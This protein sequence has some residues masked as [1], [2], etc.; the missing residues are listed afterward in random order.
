MVLPVFWALT[1][2]CNLLSDE[3]SLEDR[4]SI[5]VVAVSNA[6]QIRVIISQ[7]YFLL[8]ALP[9]VHLTG[10]DKIEWK[11]SDLHIHAH[12]IVISYLTR[13][14]WKSLKG[15][16]EEKG[17]GTVVAEFL[18]QSVI[19]C[20]QWNDCDTNVHR[21]ATVCPQLCATMW[22]Q[23]ARNCGT[24]YPQSIT[25]VDYSLLWNISTIRSIFHQDPQLIVSL[26][27]EELHLGGETPFQC[28]RRA[29]CCKLR[30]GRATGTGEKM[31]LQRWRGRRT[32][33]SLFSL[34]RCSDG[35][36]GTERGHRR[37]R[38][39]RREGHEPTPPPLGS[40]C[41]W[42]GYGD[43]RWLRESPH[44]GMEARWHQWQSA[45]WWQRT[46]E[47]DRIS[48]TTRQMCSSTQRPT[49]W[50]SATTG[51]VEWPGG[52]VAVAHEAEKRSSTTS[53]CYGDWPWTTRDLSTSLTTRRMK[54]DAIARERPVAPWWPVATGEV[55]VSI[56]SMTPPT[57]VWMENTLSTCRTGGIIVWWS[58]WK[59][60]KKGWSWPVDEV[61]GRNWRSCLILR[62]CGSMRQAASMWQI[63][64]SSRDAL[65]SR[66]HPGHCR[67]RWKRG[68]KR[69]P[70]VQSAPL[71]CSSMDRA[72][73]MSLTGGMLECN[74]F[75]WRRTE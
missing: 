7:I 58:G 52:R 74:A 30:K 44:C 40:P 35:Q 73:S 63:S 6:L 25:W 60:P 18:W 26:S 65:V 50:S 1:V 48:W 28:R 17:E 59:A 13:L 61:E 43:R 23:S 75:R 22:S 21:C 46:E 49:V 39:R 4:A 12:S 11:Y 20:A 34:F 32:S 5:F 27:T 37:W 68:G 42:A 19:S 67:G 53:T 64:E 8:Q 51:I 38:T 71:V 14:R 55:T 72:I 47:I 54:W 41:R 57:S 45:G 69:S 33:L 56:S 15:S 66:G 36:M 10:Y 16:L 3:R 24:I 31:I 2:F 9:A 70:S 62:E 29:S